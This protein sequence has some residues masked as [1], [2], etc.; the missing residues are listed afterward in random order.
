MCLQEL[1]LGQYQLGRLLRAMCA[2]AHKC[3]LVHVCAYGYSEFCGLSEGF[4]CKGSLGTACCKH[5]CV[6]VNVLVGTAD[7]RQ[8]CS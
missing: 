6:V 7:Y 8:D 5:S 3:V 1:D 4:G 2:G